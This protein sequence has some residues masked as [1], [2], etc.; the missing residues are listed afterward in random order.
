[1]KKMLLVLSAIM[2][3]MGFAS[4]SQNNETEIGD[5]E[6]ENPSEVS[7]G[8]T[9][10]EELPF[11]SGEVVLFERMDVGRVEMNNGMD[12]KTVLFSLS[13]TQKDKMITLLSTLKKTEDGH[14]LDSALGDGS[15]IITF[16]NNNRE[17]LLFIQTE[18]YKDT[19]L[20]FY[21]F[22]SDNKTLKGVYESTTDMRSE[23]EQILEE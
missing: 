6:N 3:L 4:C 18:P 16:D 8:N 2:V 21:P 1:M 10:K 20:Y 13:D 5:R 22:Y 14:L 11:A 19:G 15:I 7:D 23:I 12:R 17:R 9:N